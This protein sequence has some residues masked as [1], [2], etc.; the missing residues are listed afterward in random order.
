MSKVWYYI[1]IV[2]D[3]NLIITDR[4]LRGYSNK[5]RAPGG[6]GEVD[7]VFADKKDIALQRAALDNDGNLIVEDNPD[8]VSAGIP[9]EDSITTRIKRMEFGK[10]IIAIMSI[11][12]DAKSLDTAQIT[13]FAAD[14]ADI[15]VALQNGSIATA[16]ALINA[17][18]P[19]G[20]ITTEADK[21]ALI[22]EITA[23]ET[24]LGY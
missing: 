3:E 1:E 5:R 20:T 7:F 11:R 17:I 6:I 9:T 8:A 18:T 13:Q 24:D 19:D 12:N 14:Y 4:I 16:K 10:R 21:T 22:D 23:N 2:R 15:N